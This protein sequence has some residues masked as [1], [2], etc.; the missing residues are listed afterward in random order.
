MTSQESTKTEQTHRSTRTNNSLKVWKS[1]ELRKDDEESCKM[2]DVFI[3][4]S[5][6]SGAS[7]KCAK[8]HPN[9]AITM[10]AMQSDEVFATFEADLKKFSE[11][12]ALSYSES[13]MKKYSN[14]QLIKRET[15]LNQPRVNSFDG[16][17]EAFGVG[18]TNDDHNGLPQP[19]LDPDDSTTYTCR[20]IL[21]QRRSVT[22]VSR[23]SNNQ[24]QSRDQDAYIKLAEFDAYKSSFASSLT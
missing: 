16:W 18:H 6:P 22:K 15:F 2:F 11:L 14:N 9:Q 23:K 20:R 7:S 5:E 1:V 10:A 21:D 19:H 3:G 24:A 13:M 12:K 17:S 4:W 8:D